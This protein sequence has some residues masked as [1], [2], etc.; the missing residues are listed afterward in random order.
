MKAL[1]KITPIVIGALFAL[2]THFSVASNSD[3][4]DQVTPICPPHSTQQCMVT[5]NGT[6]IMGQWKENQNER[7]M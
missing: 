4:L 3:K 5:Q 7:R 6:V 1:L 2:N